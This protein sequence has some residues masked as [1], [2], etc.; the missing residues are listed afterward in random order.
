MLEPCYSE[1]ASLCFVVPN[2][3]AGKW[4]LVVDYRSLNAQTQHDNYTLPLIE[5]MLQK[6]FQRRIFTVINLKH[7]YHQMPL[8]EESRACTAMSTPLGPV[9][10]KVMPMGDTNSNA[11]FQRMLVNQLEP[12]RDCADPFID[13]VII[14]S[15]DP[16]MTY[17][18][19]LVAPERDVT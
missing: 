6:Q 12:V 7:G 5:D 10:W 19:L 4:R 13:H 9:Q 17:D 14:A 3:V 11:A 16:S 15:G 8:A 18:E 1:R 2:K